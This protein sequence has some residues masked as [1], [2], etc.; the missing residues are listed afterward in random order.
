M[1]KEVSVMSNTERGK[2]AVDSMARRNHSVVTLPVANK[3]KEKAEEN[4]TLL[5]R[6]HLGDPKAAKAAQEIGDDL[7]PALLDVYRGRTGIRY[8]YPLYLRSAESESD[9]PLAEPLSEFLARSIASFAPTAESARMLKDNLPRLERYIDKRLMGLIDPRDA[10]PLIAEATVAVQ[11]EVDLVGPNRDTLQKD[12]DKLLETV[13]TGGQLLG[14]GPYVAIHLLK[15]A[16]HNHT[17]VQRKQFLAQVKERIRGLD[18]LLSVEKQKSTLSREPEKVQKKVGTASMY[19]DSKALSGALG[20][21]TQGS[22]SMDSARLSR[23]KKTLALL[24]GYDADSEYIRFLA[25]QDSPWLAAGLTVDALVSSEPC[26]EAKKLYEKESDRLGK[27]FAAFRIA[28]LEIEGKYEPTVHDSWF[29]NFDWEAFSAQELLLIPT[30]VALVSSG[31]IANEGM[32]PLSRLLSS[33]KPI[34]VLCWVQAISDPGAA[35]GEIALQNIRTELAYLGLGQRQANVVQSS[36]SRHDQLTQGFCAS[37]GNSRASLY[38]VSTETDISDN[39]PLGSWMMASSAIESRAHPFFQVIRGIE[40]EAE[41]ELSITGNSQPENDWSVNTFSCQNEQGQAVEMELAFTFADYCLLS[42][43]LRDHFRMVEPGCE[44]EDLV[45]VNE[46]LDSNIEKPE[47]AIPYVLAVDGTGL[48][49]KVVVSRALIMACRD[50]QNYWRSLQAQCGIHNKYVEQAREEVREEEQA[51]GKQE[52]DQLVSKYEAE[53]ERVRQEATRD[54]MG[55]LANVLVGL[56]TAALSA[57]G[58]TAPAQAKTAPAPAEQTPDKA[59]PASAEVAAA[60]EPEAEDEVS[61]ND[62]WIDSILCTSCDDC[63]TINKM[64]FS[65][66][67][68][69]QAQITDPGKGTYADLVKAAEACPARC[70]HPGKPLNPDEPGL[71][72]LIQRA[73]AYN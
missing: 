3:D 18:Q 22:V 49:H 71:E 42:E 73:E 12:L 39:A 6:F 19:F 32:P 63:M 5:R 14:Y 34:Q 45:S 66:N 46:Y 17:H 50:R 44:S 58:A 70:I 4:I 16:V 69:K 62:P 2:S 27:V 1:A 57:S 21:K 15:L 56:D 48:L 11:K 36:A 25:E 35:T 29:E 23:I 59:E 37:L 72:E 55:K 24:E 43:A 51:S 52:R 26:V 68:D 65:Y 60:E 28:K 7:L 13:E 41:D 67:D 61:F 31:H 30:I 38:L 8:D 9:A 54:V 40:S 10:R 33:R 47:R 53:L 64:L 20:Q